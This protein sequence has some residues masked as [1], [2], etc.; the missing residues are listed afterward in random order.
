M[1]LGVQYVLESLAFL[2]MLLS[3]LI[4]CTFVVDLQ[5]Q[6]LRLVQVVV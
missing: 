5:F 6:F 4:W 2:F 3:E 1:C